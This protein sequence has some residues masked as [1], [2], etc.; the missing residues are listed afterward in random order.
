MLHSQALVVR[1]N[2]PTGDSLQLRHLLLGIHQQGQQVF[3][4]IASSGVIQQGLQIV[5]TPICMPA[6]VQGSI[7]L[8]QPTGFGGMPTERY[9]LGVGIPCRTSSQCFSAFRQ[10]PHRIPT[11]CVGN[12]PGKQV[13]TNPAAA[14]SPVAAN[15]GD[16]GH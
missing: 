15:A 11:S 8:P 9:G 10:T 7:N 13:L 4:F 1:S 6:A 16:D 3:H 12:A 5:A 14:W 2:G